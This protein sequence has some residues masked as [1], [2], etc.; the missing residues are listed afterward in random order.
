MR[1]LLLGSV[2]ATRAARQ[3]ADVVITPDTRGIGM[4]EFEALERAMEVG[5][6]AAR[7]A[8]ASSENRERLLGPEGGR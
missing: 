3:Q 4:L 1:V 7:E 8:L 5:R 6:A 2:D